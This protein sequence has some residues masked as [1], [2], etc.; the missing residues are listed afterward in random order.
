[1]VENE[2][3][4]FHKKN[5]QTDKLIVRGTKSSYIWPKSQLYCWRK[6]E[7]WNQQASWAVEHSVNIIQVKT[8][9]WGNV[10]EKKY[11]E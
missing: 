9:F 10:H 4:R 8:K 6:N 2:E 5:V 3:K 7:T 1:M 11:A